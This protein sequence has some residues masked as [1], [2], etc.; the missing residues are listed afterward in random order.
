MTNVLLSSETHEP[1]IY[2]I[3]KVEYIMTEKI[4]FNELKIGDSLPTIS[5]G[6]ISRHTIALYAAGSSDFNPIHTD[7]DFAKNHAKL[8]DVIVHGMFVM[9]YLAKIASNIV[10]PEDIKR[11][12]T[13]FRAMT[14]VKD[15][16]TCSGILKEIKATQQGKVLTFSVSACRRDKSEVAVGEIDILLP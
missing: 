14:N 16:L 13:Q 11:I 1:Q 3:G 10:P 5:T 4:N 7:S 12:K 8:L 2:H 6:P 15:D 9:G